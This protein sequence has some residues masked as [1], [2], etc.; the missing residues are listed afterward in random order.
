MGLFAVTVSSPLPN[1]PSV[2]IVVSAFQGRGN[3]FLFIKPF[4]LIFYLS[5]IDT[6][7]GV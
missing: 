5:C 4:Y 1:N 2:L 6:R 7:L 3:T